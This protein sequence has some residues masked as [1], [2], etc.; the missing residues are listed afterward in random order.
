MALTVVIYNRYALASSLNSGHPF[1]NQ[2]GLLD[3]TLNL[4][5]PIAA[6]G[7]NRNSLAL[8]VEIKARSNVGI[9]VARCYPA[10]PLPSEPAVQLFG[11][12]NMYTGM[13]NQGLSPLCTQKKG[14]I[15]NIYKVAIV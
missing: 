6:E 13:Y 4:K 1:P 5:N 12:E 3:L 11:I 14:K 7:G 8:F 2:L 10:F 15:F 9:Q